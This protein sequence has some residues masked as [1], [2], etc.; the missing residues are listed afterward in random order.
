MATTTTEVTIAVGVAAVAAVATFILLVVTHRRRARRT[1]PSPNHPA[2]RRLIT[3]APLRERAAREG[4]VYVPGMYD[5][6]PDS[7]WLRAAA[8]ERTA[9]HRG[10]ATG[11]PRTDGRPGIPDPTSP[12]YRSDDTRGWTSGPGNS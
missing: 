2:G 12:R 3:D 7:R 8:E 1:T 10:P 6:D 11:Q 9:R 4:R 5:D